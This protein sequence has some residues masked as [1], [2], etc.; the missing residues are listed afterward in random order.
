MRFIEKEQKL[1]LKSGFFFC[2]AISNNYKYVPLEGIYISE[3]KFTI[4]MHYFPRK[5]VQ[6]TVRTLNSI[7]MEY[8][9]GSP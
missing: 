7:W 9:I 4:L 3:D 6:L 5:M 1:C 2:E 8:A